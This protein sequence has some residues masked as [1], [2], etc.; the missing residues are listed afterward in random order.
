MCHIYTCT[1]IW[2]QHGDNMYDNQVCTFLL[3]YRDWN[4][5]KKKRGDLGHIHKF[6]WLSGAN[7]YP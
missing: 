4:N 5:K 6:H 3:V 1:L 2:H 7:Q